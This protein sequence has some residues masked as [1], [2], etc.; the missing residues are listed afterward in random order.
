MASVVAVVF[1]SEEF[2]KALDPTI[3]LVMILRGG[4][5]PFRS[6]LAKLPLA[7]PG[8]FIVG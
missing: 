6:V 8:S 5:L 1:E 2:A 3:L 7:E 4:A